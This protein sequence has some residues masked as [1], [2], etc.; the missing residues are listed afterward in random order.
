MRRLRV[1]WVVL[2]ANFAVGCPMDREDVLEDKACDEDGT[3]ALGFRCR[4]D[5][6][7][8]DDRDRER[9]QGLTFDGAVNTEPAA[10]T[11][12]ARDAAAAERPE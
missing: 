10:N 7:V 6:C 12:P 11:E 1:L 5:K 4:D 2:A 9:A 3:C 8:L